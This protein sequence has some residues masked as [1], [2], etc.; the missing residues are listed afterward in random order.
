MESHGFEKIGAFGSKFDIEI[1][2]L[3]N[4]R[5]QVKIINGNKIQQHF[6]KVGNKLTIKLK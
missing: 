6:I 1:D 5:L 4:N 3:P 2:R